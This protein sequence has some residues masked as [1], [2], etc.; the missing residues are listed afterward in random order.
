MAIT[1]FWVLF[2]LAA[3][4]PVRWVVYLFFAGMAFGSFNTIPGGFNLT[5]YGA[6]APLLAAK[7]LGERGASHR[8]GDAVLNPLR[9]GG[10]SAFVLY[11]LTVTATA[12]LLFRGVIIMGLNTNVEAPLR[13]GM[14]NL[15]QA[16]YLITA[17]LVTISMFVLIRRPGGMAILAQALLVGGAVVV[18]AGLADMLTAGSGM[19][20]PLRTASY[21]MIAQAEMGGMR[22]VIGFNS[23][24]S[25]Y[26]GITLFFGTSLLFIRPSRY[27]GA[28]GRKVEPVLT[29][30]LLVFCFLSTSSSAYLGLGA[31]L[32]LYCGQL[33]VQ[34]V[35]VSHS[36][37]GHRATIKLLVLVMAVW[38]G[39]LAVMFHPAFAT[40]LQR[41]INEALFQKAG[42]DS[43]LERMSWSR[44][45]MAA[46]MHSGGYGVGLGSTRASSFPVAVASSTGVFGSALLVFYCGRCLLASLWAPDTVGPGANEHGGAWRQSVVGARLAWVV[47]LVPAA[48]AATTVDLSVD[49]LFF[50]I[51][52][53][54]GMAL[55]A[56]GRSR[57]P[58]A[59]D[60]PWAAWPAARPAIRPI[61]MEAESTACLVDVGANPAGAAR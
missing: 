50:A 52:A 14:G 36:P 6:T 24:A 21:A 25:G 18:A 22:R 57:R 41:V 5:P 39:A 13:Y 34:A 15:T 37:A 7:L 28:L 29:L 26:G 33:V 40:P 49:A 31:A 3:I 1:I 46:L 51:M 17:W 10:L 55:P 45:S 38:T 19:L 8:L 54:A 4:L 48:G 30:A 35:T 59:V 61:P 43:Y 47:G 53:T 58:P 27:A 32:V 9:F 44:V 20:A 16:I 11:A 2:A 42:T 60:H 23:E 12:P 56:P